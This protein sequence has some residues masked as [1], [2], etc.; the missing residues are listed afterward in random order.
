MLA[1]LLAFGIVAAS[2]P[3]DYPVARKGDVVEDHFGTKIAD[4]YRW[5]EDVDAPEVKSWVEAE[6][7][8]TFDYLRAIPQWKAIRSR[9]G[10]LL[11]YERVSA[12]TKRGP[13][14]FFTR[15]DGVRNQ[16]VWYVKEGNKE[17]VLL[18][19]N[20]LR[21]DGTASVNTEAA[22]LDGRYWAYALS[23]GGSDWMEW[24]IIDVKTGKELPEV[25]KWAKFSGAGWAKDGSGFFYG[26]YDTPADGVGLRAK[27]TDQKVFFHKVGTDQAQDKL[28]Y[29]RPQQPEWYFGVDCTEDGKYEILGTSE[30]S[31][32]RNYIAYR[33]AGRTGSFTELP[34]KAEC[35]Y[36]LL[37][38]D[39]PVFYVLTNQDAGRNKIVSI[40]IRKPDFEN[41]KVIVP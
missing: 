11:V 30:S 40:D 10:E 24:H 4:P 38:N 39:G 17:R 37:G 2:G 3:F 25:L 18:D 27:N 29:E 32:P 6:N 15:F 7:K 34:G 23:F 33:P 26:R 13:Y 41:W 20:T 28:M 16:A 14:S 19:P 12:P 8:L 36:S 21:A 35:S 22:S 5:M 31:S 9:L 1:S